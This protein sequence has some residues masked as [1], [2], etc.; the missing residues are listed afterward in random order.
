M[1]MLRRFLL[2]TGLSGL[3][4]ETDLKISGRAEASLTKGVLERLEGRFE[5]G[6]G[7][8]QIEDKDTSPFRV[9]SLSASVSWDEARRRLALADILFKGGEPADCDTFQ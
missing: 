2:L 5:G 1:G 6:G 4:A 7:M 3:P 9:D 8:V